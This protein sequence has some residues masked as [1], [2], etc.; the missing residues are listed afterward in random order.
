MKS[1]HTQIVLVRSVLSELPQHIASRAV[2]AGHKATEAALGKATPDG[3]GGAPDHLGVVARRLGEI[4]PIQRP[5]INPHLYPLSACRED[6]PLR[7]V[8]ACTPG[9]AVV[10]VCRDRWRR[11]EHENA[12]EK[13]SKN[14][15]THHSFHHCGQTRS[16]STTAELATRGCLTRSAQGSRPSSSVCCACQ[17][18]PGDQ[19]RKLLKMLRLM[20]VLAGWS[21]LLAGWS[22]GLWLLALQRDSKSPFD[23]LKGSESQLQQSPC[24][25]GA[26]TMFATKGQA[27]LAWIRGDGLDRDAACGDAGHCRLQLEVSEAACIAVLGS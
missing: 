19:D 26:V 3:G 25:Q 8:L 10:S 18:R 21:W 11:R 5:L 1:F 14:L 15:T 23:W 22:L 16:G 2:Q 6:S 13:I 7:K 27:S 24:Y 12:G 9:F 20:R 4:T 17:V